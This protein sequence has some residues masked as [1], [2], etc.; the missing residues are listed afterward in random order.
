MRLD[1]YTNKNGR[2]KYALLKLRNLTKLEEA[3]ANT[4]KLYVGARK[5]LK[6]RLQK[7]RAALKVLEEASILDY[8]T[9]DRGAAFFVMRF[10]DPY[11]LPALRTYANAVL[12]DAGKKV[13]MDLMLK[14]LEG[15]I[16]EPERAKF[17]QCAAQYRELQE[18]YKDLRALINEACLAPK[19]P[20]IT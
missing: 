18:F 15:T 4:P 11:T 16:T 13:D 17:S 3:L 8:G 7:V 9:A 1:R 20:T 12:N 10:R 14:I 2:G 19:A 6:A 5:K